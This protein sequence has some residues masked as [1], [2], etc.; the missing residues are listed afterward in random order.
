MILKDKF[1]ENLSY[2][3]KKSFYYC[4]LI[5]TNISIKGYFEKELLNIYLK[6]LCYLILQC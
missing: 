6:L 4:N 3:T 1:L 2:G 5:V